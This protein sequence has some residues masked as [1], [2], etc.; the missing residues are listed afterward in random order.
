MVP[1]AGLLHP[2]MSNGQ[3]GTERVERIGRRLIFV[4]DCDPLARRFQI[5]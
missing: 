2:A 1:V 5:G 4:D 3:Q